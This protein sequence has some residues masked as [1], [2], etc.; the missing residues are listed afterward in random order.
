MLMYLFQFVAV[1]CGGADGYAGM[2]FAGLSEAYQ[3]AYK[4]RSYGMAPGFGGLSLRYTGEVLILPRWEGLP[5]SGWSVAEPK[6]PV[7]YITTGQPVADIPR[8]LESTEIRSA[9]PMP[10]RFVSPNGADRIHLHEG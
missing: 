4:G 8:Q 6:F 9:I 3:F 10:V 5:G 7:R 2:F 1:R